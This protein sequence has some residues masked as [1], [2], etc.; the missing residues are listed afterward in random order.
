MRGRQPT[1]MRP[2]LL[3]PRS[4]HRDRPHRT[5][6]REPSPHTPVPHPG[7]TQPG[8]ERLHSQG[9]VTPCRSCIST[10]TISTTAPAR[11]RAKTEAWC[12]FPCAAVAMVVDVG[13][14]APDDE[15]VS[16]GAAGA[17]SLSRSL[18]VLSG[19][20]SEVRPDFSSEPARVCW[21][22]RSQLTPAA[23]RAGKAVARRWRTWRRSH[24]V[25]SGL[26]AGHDE[27]SCFPERAYIAFACHDRVLVDRHAA[28]HTG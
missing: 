13:A 22:D 21:L 17:R 28:A 27:L 1:I 16:R 23:A 2:V 6:H 20:R 18:I 12:R 8:T 7:T 9:S 19:S 15:R 24:V 4:S 11:V 3:V 5:P 26:S 14:L 25:Q 10:R